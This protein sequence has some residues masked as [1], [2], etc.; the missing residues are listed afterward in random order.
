MSVTVFTTASCPQCLVTKRHLK[1]RNVEFE[2]IRIDQNPDWADRLK[3]MGFM[4][5]P[6]VLVED[7]DVWSGYSSDSIEEWFPKQ[8][9]AA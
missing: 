3:G 2:E 7:D 5:A 1:D 4:A 6:V 9:T 8:R